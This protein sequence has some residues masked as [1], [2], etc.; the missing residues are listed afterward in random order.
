M[1]VH[2]TNTHCLSLVEAVDNYFC[3][4]R[5]PQGFF[6]GIFSPESQPEKNMSLCVVSFYYFFFLFIGTK[7]LP[8]N[9]NQPLLA[10]NFGL[11]VLPSPEQPHTRRWHF[12]P[13]SIWVTVSKEDSILAVTWLL[14]HLQNTF[15]L[16]APIMLSKEVS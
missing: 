11:S 8:L 6:P 1:Q 12:C 14:E 7:F 2:Q 9:L 3:S 16:K 13:S 4:Y 5:I 15:E 10:R